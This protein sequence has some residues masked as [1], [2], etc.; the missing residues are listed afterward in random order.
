MG[1]LSQV[2]SRGRPEKG[3]GKV[4]H[5]GM[6]GDSSAILSQTSYVDNTGIDL[7]STTDGYSPRK[8]NIEVGLLCLLTM[9]L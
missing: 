6:I 9:V 8:T 7:L 5:L 4:Q 2:E 1:V 3:K